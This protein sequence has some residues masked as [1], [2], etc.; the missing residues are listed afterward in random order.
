VWRRGRSGA[1]RKAGTRQELRT[2]AGTRGR[3]QQCVL[4]G[5]A[6]A[7]RLAEGARSSNAAAA[8]G[9][10]VVQSKGRG[11]GGPRA[12]SPR[13]HHHPQLRNVPHLL[14]AP[15]RFVQ[16]A[17]RAAGRG[18]KV[19]GGPGVGMLRLWWGAWLPLEALP[20]AGSWQPAGYPVAVP[21]TSGAGANTL[22]T[23]PSP[24]LGPFAA[25]CCSNGS[26][27]SCL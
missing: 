27:A 12:P 26:A 17:P 2:K 9:S 18:W 11:A 7:A 23:R 3:Q 20:V 6:D 10:P 19:R 15:P 8:G 16:L 4:G 22:P 14:H 5:C 25:L 21:P 24:P 13:R 1:G